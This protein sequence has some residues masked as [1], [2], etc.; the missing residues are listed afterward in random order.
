MYGGHIT[1]P[2]DRRVAIAYL[3]EYMTPEILTGHDFQPGFKCPE[4]DKDYE[5]YKDYIEDSFPIETPVLFGL[6]P[7]A[8]IGF[9][10][11]TGHALFTTIVDLGGAGG[12]AE[13]SSASD[14][15]KD[16]LNDLEARLPLDFAMHEIRDKIV[17]EGPYISVV[18][19]ECG[20]MNKLL[21][22]MRRS[23]AE[24]QLG[25]AGS[26][27]MSDSMETLL[28]S[29][30]LNRVAPNWASNAYP[31]RKNLSLWFEDM[32]LRVQ[33]LTLWS[34]NLETPVSVWITAL[35]N[36]MAYITAIL[37]TTARLK[38]LPLDQMDIWT[39]VLETMEPSN[40]SGY[41]EEGM[42]IHGFFMEGARWDSK[43]GVVTDSVPKELH[44]VVPVVCVRGLV[45][46]SYSNE[47]IYKCPVYT[48]SIRGPTYVFP[49]TL[50]SA[51][52]INKWV[53]AGVCMLMNDD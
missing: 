18:L 6:H 46:G 20:R 8:E 52:K 32:L 26:L 13:G 44:P 2:W 45:H 22:E 9:L 29:L 40:L 16:V 33:Q 38:D 48:T 24:L 53:L 50:K 41:P 43:K 4:V 42:Y 35:F 19:Q 28:V 10:V 47:G 49:A 39:D 17:D 51:D 27:N 30:R 37:Q 34:S 14:P 31:S 36:P 25:L 1:D 23:M 15:A 12:G 21:G 7:N 5:Y 11:Q 3:Q